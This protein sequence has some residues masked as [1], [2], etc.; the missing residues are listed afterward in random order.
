[1]TKHDDLIF[2]H[3]CSTLQHVQDP[4]APY[5]LGLWDQVSRHTHFLPLLLS[6]MIIQSFKTIFD[7]KTHRD[8]HQPI[9]LLKLS[10][11]M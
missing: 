2:R 7:C 11:G 9:K 5:T 8:T 10:S 6:F 1:M 3:L 4:P